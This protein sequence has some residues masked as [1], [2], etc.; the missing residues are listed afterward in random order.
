MPLGSTVKTGLGETRT[1]ILGAQ[2][3]LGFQLHGAFQQRFDALPGAARGT[4][5]A[6]L[7]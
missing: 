6:A 3:L 5:A 4:S 7:C 2:I 1:L